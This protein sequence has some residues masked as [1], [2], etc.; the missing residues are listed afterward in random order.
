MDAALYDYFGIYLD[1]PRSGPFRLKAVEVLFHWC[2][3]TYE[4]EIKD[5]T[6]NM[7]L[8][9]SHT[10]LHRGDAVAPTWSN[11]TLGNITYLTSPAD[12]GGKY[13]FGGSG[14]NSIWELLNNSLSG[15]SIN[16]GD[17]QFSTGSDMLIH[18]DAVKKNESTEGW[19]EVIDGMARNIAAGLT[20]S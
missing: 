14:V 5:N 16:N 2:I 18:A 8:A 6:L 19:L 17:N 7:K 12:E 13:V 10:E 20:N 11:D 9:L 15:F 1:M 3:N 4:P